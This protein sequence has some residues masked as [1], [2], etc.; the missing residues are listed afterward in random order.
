[1]P[2]NIVMDCFRDRQKDQFSIQQFVL[3]R[4]LRLQPP[5]TGRKKCNFRAHPGRI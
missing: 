1:M 4:R 2:A 5:T 3:A